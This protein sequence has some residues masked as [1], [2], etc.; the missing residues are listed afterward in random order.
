MDQLNR[1]GQRY[2]GYA[3]DHGHVAPA[4]DEGKTV[5]PLPGQAD[6]SGGRWLKTSESRSGLLGLIL[7][8]VIIRFGWGHIL[9]RVIDLIGLGQDSQSPL[10]QRFG[11]QHLGRSQ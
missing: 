2:T 6:Q 1:L 4:E 7:D 11:D 5:P 8:L 10:G 9:I 3:T